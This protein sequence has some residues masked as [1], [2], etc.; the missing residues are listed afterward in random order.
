[1]VFVFLTSC[2]MRIFSC[3]HVLQVL[4]F[5]SFIWLS[6]IPLCILPYLL[7][8]FIC[9]WTFR[10][11]PFLDIVNSV[12]MN[13]GMHVSFWIIVWSRYMTRSGIT[14]LYAN[15]I[16]SFL[17]NR[18]TVLHCGCTN[19]HSQQCRSV[20]FPVEFILKWSEF[21]WEI[22]RV[23]KENFSPMSKEYLRD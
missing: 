11:F 16:F 22:M 15:C 10:L 4:L 17:R 12:A 8:F 20:P 3:T 1:M 19:S 7:Y 13:I 21:L 14:G 18:H 2:S 5:H 9:Q 23:T 6:N